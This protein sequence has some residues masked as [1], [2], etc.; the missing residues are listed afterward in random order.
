MAQ[1]QFK[2]QRNGHDW[3]V[4]WDDKT[5]RFT[6]D[7]PKIDTMNRLLD[8]PPGDYYAGVFP[9]IG[10][11]QPKTD[12]ADLMGLLCIALNIYTENPTINTPPAFKDVRTRYPKSFKFNPNVEY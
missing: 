9:P 10:C 2:I 4:V 8:N 12:K 7:H 6:G 3:S 11:Y 1:H 5:Q